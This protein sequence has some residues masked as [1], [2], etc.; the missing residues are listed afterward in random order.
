MAAKQIRK[1]GVLG[2]GVMGSGIA[3][4][5]AGAG[6]PVLLLDIVPPFP[7]PA[8]VDAK[9]PAW[10]NKFS[11]DAKEKLLKTK[12]ASYHSKADAELIEV[13][14]L[15]DDLAR[16]NECDWVCE[17]VKEDLKVKRDLFARI[18]AL[19]HADLVL[20][21]NTSGLPIAA[22]TEGMSAGFRSHFFVTHFFNPPRYMRLLEIVEG[23]ETD[24][25][26]LGRTVAF[27]E[28]VLGK[29]IV[30][31]KDTPNFV[32]NRIGTFGMLDAIHMML[33]D[34]LAPE[35][36]DALL[37]TP[38]GHPKSALFRTGDIV[39][40]DTFSH[41]AKNCYD[42]LVDDE[43]RDTFKLPEYIGKM[44]AAGRLG[45]KSKG[46]FYRKGAEGLET[47]DPKTGEYRPNVK[48]RLPLLKEL[49]DI[50]D[51]GGRLRAIWA[52]AANNDAHA[53]YA[54][55]LT[56]RSLAY[57]ARR[58]GEIADDVVQID[59]AMKWGFN[60]E[61]GPFE[62]W[63]A[64]GFTELAPA[65]QKFGLKLPAWV[66]EML[67]AGVPGFYRDNGTEFYDP[68]AKAW[69]KVPTSERALR[70]PRRDDAKKVVEHN[71]SATLF[72]I[73]DGVFCVEFHSKMNS[74]DPMNTE[75]MIKGVE[76]AEKNGV[77]LVI[78]NEAT[79]AFSAGANL[80]LVLMTA[81]QAADDAS[82]WPQ[83]EAQVKGFQDANQRLK[84]AGVPVVA[85]P[86]G[87]TLGGGCEIALGA[88]AI[89]AH[90]ELYMGLVEVGVGLIPG[91]GGTKE[92]LWR[93]TQNV[94]EQDDL[95]PAIQRAFETIA[96]AKI[97]FSAAEAK[98]LGYLLASD[99]ITFNRDQLIG[100][101]KATVQAMNLAGFRPTRPRQFRVGGTQAFANIQA[102]VWS[103][104]QSHQISEHDKKIATKLG[105]VLTGGNVPANSR[106]S[107]QYLLDL[108]REAFMSLVGEEKTKERMQFM[109]MNGKPLRN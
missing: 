88:Q 24:A 26:A 46:G 52:A 107:E 8:G 2:A 7:P 55:T 70:L 61:L 56:A 3:A 91:G 96:L 54:L 73:G 94:R 80:F 71:E 69:R 13:G 25:A 51:I 5:I 103:M 82:V 49:K 37:G 95:F 93:L 11:L 99:R 30:Y 89:R 78:A 31:G 75:M 43:E 68:F 1:V 102:A 53:R 16:L 17:A 4:H 41:V 21:S 106:V 45:D 92:V 58:L 15:E 12:P 23:P 6:Y 27:G 81:N 59:R 85:A 20:T 28:D 63:D 64:I 104:E 76:Y 101:A 100:D 97:S 19:R 65:M 109:L 67:A 36:V 79:D 47:L 10:R 98:E 84:Y 90:A 105:Y 29:G 9:S 74:V 48:A 32:A 66:D 108:E 44:V 33:K 86:F 60:W 62:T 72:D 40:L 83:L 42:L 35:E 57:S 50:E 22:M 34:G 77:G 87:L 14:N 39:G 38:V 18:D